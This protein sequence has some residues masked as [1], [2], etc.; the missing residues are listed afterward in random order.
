M[1]VNVWTT[2]TYSD[3]TAQVVCSGAGESK[4]KPDE[5]WCCAHGIEWGHV[6]RVRKGYEYRMG[7]YLWII[8]MRK[9]GPR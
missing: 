7:K 4:R 6:T 9:D 3:G 2:T 5:A 8:E 1:I